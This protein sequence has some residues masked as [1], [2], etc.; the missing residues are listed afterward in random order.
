MEL[1][2]WFAFPCATASIF[3]NVDQLVEVELACAHRCSCA[4]WFAFPLHN[5]DIL[6]KAFYVWINWFEQANRW[7]YPT[8]SRFRA[9]QRQS[10][11]SVLRV[12]QLV[13]AVRIDAV[14]SWF[15]EFSTAFSARINYF[16]TLNC[17]DRLALRVSCRSFRWVI[18]NPKNAMMGMV[19]SVFGTY[20]VFVNQRS[21]ACVANKLRGAVE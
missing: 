20:I 18:K 10:F 3:P 14:W 12:D 6:S 13:W 7:S 17:H 11:Q 9:R 15:P 4:D 2:D 21:V 8:D 1:P 19:I 16:S 5:R